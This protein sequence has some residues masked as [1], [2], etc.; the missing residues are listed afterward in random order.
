MSDGLTKSARRVFDILEL[1]RA[2]M[3]AASERRRLANDEGGPI[4]EAV[5][6]IGRKLGE[7]ILLGM[8]TAMQEADFTLPARAE[9]ADHSARSFARLRRQYHEQLAP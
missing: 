6:R 7:T 5:R 4:Q 8:A 9:Y 3:P 1:F 2:A